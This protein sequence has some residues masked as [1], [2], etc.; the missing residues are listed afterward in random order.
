[1]VGKY[2]LGRKLGQG[3]FGKVKQATHSETG[4]L[5]ALKLLDRK[6]ISASGMGE[7]IKKEIAVM[8]SLQHRNIVQL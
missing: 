4:R 3:T 7:Q 2:I 5:V 8:Q 1:M 6:R